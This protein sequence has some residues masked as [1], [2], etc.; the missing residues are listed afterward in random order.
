MVWLLIFLNYSIGQPNPWK[1][2]QGSN[3]SPD[4]PLIKSLSNRKFYTIFRD[5]S[6]SFTNFLIQTFSFILNDD[7]DLYH[8]SDW[9]I[10]FVFLIKLV[11]VILN[12]ILICQYTSCD[13]YCNPDWSVHFVF[14]IGQCD[15]SNSQ[16]GL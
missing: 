6:N 8:N 5:R 16:C 11:N 13:F 9:S 1:W 10:L 12:G 7:Y 15:L 3:G 2:S 4:C 14:L